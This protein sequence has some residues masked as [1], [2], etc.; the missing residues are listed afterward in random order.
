MSKRTKV[1]FNVESF[2]FPWVLG[3]LGIYVDQVAF[4]GLLALN[5][6]VL[7]CIWSAMEDVKR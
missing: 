5:I 6:L 1:L 7:T 4:W 3:W 2:F